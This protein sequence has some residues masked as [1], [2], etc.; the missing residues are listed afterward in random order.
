MRF[1]WIRTPDPQI[2]RLA[3]FVDNS[4]PSCK[5]AQWTSKEDQGL[6]TT[7]ANQNGAIA[8]PLGEMLT[9]VQA[10]R[11]LKG[12]YGFGALGMLAKLAMTGGGPLF[13][14]YSTT[15]SLYPLAG[16]DVWALERLGTAR[17]SFKG[18]A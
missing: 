11:Y 14:K 9:R 5:P 3:G 1:P 4:T 2:R 18:A 15:R 7:V 6:T 8:T 10:G 16:L 17:T 13:H 12:K